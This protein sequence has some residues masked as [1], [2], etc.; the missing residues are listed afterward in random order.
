[1]CCCTNM[2]LR[3]IWP[4]YVMR[5]GLHVFWSRLGAW[6]VTRTA[7]TNSRLTSLQ[8]ADL[9]RCESQIRI[10]TP[11]LLRDI[12]VCLLFSHVS[13]L[14]F[15]SILFHLFHPCQ[16]SVAGARLIGAIFQAL[17]TLEV[18][19]VLPLSSPRSVYC[20]DFISM[21]MPALC[22]MINLTIPS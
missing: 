4:L 10:C 17:R 6:I 22:S 3:M 12:P 20:M 8:N 21:E 9:T 16:T 19:T 14:C 1:M 7:L 2:K 18:F 13:L 15:P 5:K 11:T